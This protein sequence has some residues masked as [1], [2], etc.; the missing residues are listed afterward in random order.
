MA[1]TETF[2]FDLYLGS[3]TPLEVTDATR[4]IYDEL[5]Q[6]LTDGT[7]TTI[8]VMF[9]T[10]HA[11]HAITINGAAVPWWQIDVSLDVA[12]RLQLFT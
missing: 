7:T 10:D 8:T 6:A 1:E 11:R 9:P 2:S 3:T 12:G 5:R 4:A